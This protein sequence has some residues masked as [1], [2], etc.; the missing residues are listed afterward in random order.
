MESKNLVKG[1]EGKKE[2]RALASIRRAALIFISMAAPL[3]PDE[4]AGC[5]DQAQNKGKEQ[6]KADHGNGLLKEG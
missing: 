6:E 4:L 3:S 1:E 2:S 5:Q